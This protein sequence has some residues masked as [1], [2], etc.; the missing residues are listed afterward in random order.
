MTFP[1]IYLG[2]IWWKRKNRHHTCHPPMTSLFW[3]GHMTKNRNSHNSENFSLFSKKI[4]M[5]VWTM[6]IYNSASK[7]YRHHVIT[8]WRHQFSNLSKNCWY[9]HI[10]ALIWF[11]FT[12]ACREWPIL[13]SVRFLWSQHNPM[14]RNCN[15]NFCWHQ[16]KIKCRR[17]QYQ[18]A[19]C[20]FFIPLKRKYT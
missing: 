6:V 8:W 17:K 19:I 16:Q 14:A 7:F 9:K 10:F 12:V 3:Q 13:I 18:L 4:G 5:W 1:K 11:F 20:D 2:I 15:F